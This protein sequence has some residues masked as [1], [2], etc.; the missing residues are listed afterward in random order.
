MAPA[1][2]SSHLVTF[3]YLLGFRYIGNQ[4]VSIT[5]LL[6]FIQVFPGDLLQPNY[7]DPDN[8]DRLVGRS[9]V[10]RRK[11]YINQL[12]DLLPGGGKHHLI[13]MIKDCL[14]NAPSQR[15]TVEQLV[16]LLEG[17]KGDVEGPC[18]ELATM[19]A[20]RQ[21]KTVMALKKEK[22]DQLATK[23][24][25]IWQLQQQLE[26][27]VLPCMLHKTQNLRLTF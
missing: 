27:H 22:V 12:E 3:L 19:D 11:A 15:P 5:I 9:E 25:E 6:S 16:T 13:Q 23:D 1:L 20:A 10:G 18:G 2:M 14:H 8:P 24:Q 26:V 4:F 7:I 21:V 17:M